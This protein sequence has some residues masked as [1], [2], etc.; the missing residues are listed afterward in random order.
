MHV[1]FDLDG[2]LANIEHR[3][4]FIEGPKK[5]WSAFFRACGDDLPNEPVCETLRM[6][7]ENPDHYVEI[8]SGR[9][10]EVRVLTEAWL[11]QHGLSY[12][13]LRM[14]RAGDYRQDA[15]VKGEWLDSYLAEHGKL[16]DLSFDDRAQVVAMWRSRGVT[17]A[18]V[19]EGEF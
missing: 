13:R 17:C 10:D 18:Q 7:A 3:L 14:R 6:F 11:C 12:R 16:P 4:H 1:I 5:S 8:W 15:I 9:S 2:T 19:A